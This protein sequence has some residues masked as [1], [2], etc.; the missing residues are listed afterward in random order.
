M[1]PKRKAKADNADGAAPKM[2]AYQ[3][4]VKEALARVKA[5]NPSLGHDA[6]FRMVA[7]GW[8]QHPTNPKRAETDW[9]TPLFY[10]RGAVDGDAWSGTWV[11]SADGLPSDADS[12]AENIADKFGG[13]SMS[14]PATPPAVLLDQG[15]GLAGLLRHLARGARDAHRAT[16]ARRARR[17]GLGRRRRDRQH[18]AGRFVSLGR[19]DGAESYDSG[20]S[21][22]TLARRYLDD[23]DPQVGM[24]AKVAMPPAAGRRWALGAPYCAA[25]EDPAVPEAAFWARRRGPRAARC[26]SRRSR[27]A[28]RPP[29][30]L[31]DGGHRVGVGVAPALSG[32]SSK[33]LLRRRT[34]R[35]DWTCVRRVRIRSN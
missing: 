5:L 8:K 17:R 32:C 15:D 13:K 28:A 19:L 16:T 21:R 34:K 3:A 2:S 31:R 18:R 25:V 27:A 35:M 9:R 6:A 24:S 1:A 12:P 11:A 7:A 4:Y 26:W 30:Q 33:S 29:R 14:S 20:Y 23:D 22:L 10:W